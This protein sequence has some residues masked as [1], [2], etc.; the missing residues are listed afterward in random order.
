M[1][2]F[3]FLI[4]SRG[5]D[6]KSYPYLR[7]GPNYN[8]IKIPPIIKPH[9]HKHK[10]EEILQR[11]YGFYFFTEAD[12][13]DS[14]HFVIYYGVIDESYQED[15]PKIKQW[16]C[17]L[18]WTEW[19]VTKNELLNP[20]GSTFANIKDI[21][22]NKYEEFLEACPKEEH[23][24][25]DFDREVIKVTCHKCYIRWDKGEGWFKWLSNFI[26]YKE[27]VSVE[28]RFHSEVG[29]RKGSWKGGITGT[30]I[31]SSKE[32]S[33]KSALDRWIGEYLG[34]C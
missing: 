32:E 7:I 31:T 3:N 22:W 10:Y 19:R 20:D 34:D 26:P 23:E 17:F 8:R 30:S 4:Y 18:P 6:S 15:A 24:F 21:P 33:M 29:R 14:V 1:K 16:S 12:T 27:R 13:W 28:F 11:S 2:I 9:I 25:V 5:E